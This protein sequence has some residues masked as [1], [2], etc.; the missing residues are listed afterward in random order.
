MEEI[1]KVLYRLVPYLKKF[2]FQ[3]FSGFI[4]IVLQNYG[5]VKVPEYM[6]KIL[7]EITGNNNKEVVIK[8]ALIAFGYTLFTAVCMYLM[9]KTIIGVSRKVEFQLR[10][11]LY[12]KFLQLDTNFYLKNQTGDLTSRC[13][14]DLNDV[15]T[16]LGPGLMYVP[17]SL[18]R[19]LLFFPVLIALNKILML[20]ISIVLLF[21]IVLIFFTMPKLKPL[22][23]KIQ[24]ST[25][26]VSSSAWQIIAGITSIKLN[27]LEKIET[28]RFEKLNKKYIK[29]NMDMVKWRG[30][31]WPFFIFI[32]SFAELL[33]LYFGG[34]QII[35]G[36]MT[37]GDL[38]QFNM[39]IAYLTFPVLS[40][41]WIMSL[42]QQGIS[43]MERISYILNQEIENTSILKNINK[44]SFE[45]E[46]RN[47]NYKYP[48][49]E[50]YVL[51]NISFKI[52]PSETLGITGTI[53][54]GKSTIAN[55]ISGI[56]KPEN[57][58]VFINGNDINS[59]NPNSIFKSVSVV[60]QD[61]FLFSKSIKDNISLGINCDFEKIQN[62]AK[63]AGL[64]LDIERF[65]NKY[66]E[67]VGEK[68][69]TLS[70][71]QIQ[72]TAIARALIRKS[73]L[74]IFDDALSSV[75]AKTENK[76]LENLNKYLKNNNK[77]SFILISHRISALK[78]TDRIIVLDKG[79]IVQTGTHDQLKSQDGLYRKLALI[80]QLKG[81]DVD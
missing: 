38:L 4:F 63:V 23:L 59:I 79:K 16:L 80:Q 55:I 3:L 64:H 30:F 34:K 60:P 33:V 6:K 14:N 43:A 2:K 47:L 32:L 61:P 73:I 72:R 27:N 65:P 5:Y 21:L 56:L 10:K 13:T 41:G 53:G 68:G 70:G 62:A 69:I 67:M 57:N 25:G 39:M 11:D 49:T 76:I 66:N 28:E 45:I 52:K 48:E 37:I 18:T 35:A 15:R 17:N 36:K 26:E 77:K 78:Q 50:N 29:A 20:Y 74:T 8:F 51:E 40:L 75:D 24:E 81:E 42:I 31:L 44:D 19:F 71:G 7:N 9:R 1:I 54:S 12:E 58:Q 46:F 22:F